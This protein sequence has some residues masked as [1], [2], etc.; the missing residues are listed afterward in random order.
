MPPLERSSY[1][2]SNLSNPRGWGL[3][4]IITELESQNSAVWHYSD[5]I[6]IPSSC[7]LC[8]AIVTIA[9]FVFYQ[10]HQIGQVSKQSKSKTGKCSNNHRAASYED[11]TQR[12]DLCGFHCKSIN[13]KLYICLQF[14][15]VQN[16]QHFALHSLITEESHC[17]G[18]V[19]FKNNFSANSCTIF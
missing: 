9:T 1:L 8:R 5:I 11:L 16:T 18:Y 14:L 4:W 13:A 19:E 17:R 15:C 10:V 6:T 2:V 12:S 3:I 7:D